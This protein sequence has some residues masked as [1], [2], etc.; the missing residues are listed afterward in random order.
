MPYRIYYDSYQ[1]GKWFEAL[2]PDL[3][4]SDLQ[5]FPR[6]PTGKLG[7]VLGLDRP[8]IVLTGLN[9]EPIL[10][11]ERTVEVPSGHNVGQR[12]ARLVA[13]AIETV[14][15]VYFGPYAAMKH[16]GETS[17]PRYMNLRLFKALRVLELVEK[18][19][20]TTIRWH[21]D[22]DHELLKT[23][24]KDDR[25][26]EY[27]ELFFK[28]LKNAPSIADLAHT[29]LNSDFEKEQ[30]A[31]R[32]EFVR[33]EVKRSAGY[34]NPPNSLLLGVGGRLTADLLGSPFASQPIALYDV[35]MKYIRSDPYTGTALLYSYLYCGGLKHRKTPLILRFP[36]ITH[37]M[38]Q[39]AASGRGGATKTI[40]LFRLASDAIIF[41]DAVV[42]AKDL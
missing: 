31:E 6:N 2:H 33:R 36:N 10:V 37:A 13:A 5:P 29:I 27:L 8:D 40:R 9:D 34:D 18:S 26:R 11:V 21:T 12:F 19:P 3:A 41:S 14:P 32:D 16:G 42:L 22:N 35:G 20:V 23:P 4:G 15:C 1:E 17:G 30:E 24:A 38:W 25:M 39:T 7:G 28:E